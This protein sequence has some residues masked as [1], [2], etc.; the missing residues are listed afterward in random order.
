MLIQVQK[1][2]TTKESEVHSQSQQ[3]WS[4]SEQH[5]PGS[6][7]SQMLHSEPIPHNQSS[8]GQQSHL[9]IQQLQLQ[10]LENE[11]KMLEAL[12]QQQSQR[13]AKTHQ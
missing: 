6:H 12:Q 8:V 3:Q 5:Y 10:M 1:E 4:Q 13:Q 2:I 9:E 7:S 11:Q